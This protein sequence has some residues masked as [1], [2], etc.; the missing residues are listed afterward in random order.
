MKRWSGVPFLEAIRPEPGWQ[1]DRAAFASYSADLVAVMASLLALAGLDDHQGSGS[2]VSVAQAL[3]DLRGRVCFVLQAGRLP[4]PNVSRKILGVLD[5]FLRE[6]KLHEGVQAWH[7]KIAVARMVPSKPGPEGVE[8]RVWIGS[9]NLTR[10]IAF[11]S[12]LT[13]RGRPRLPNTD[14]SSGRI[15]GVGDMIEKLFSQTGLELDIP[16]DEF[17]QIAWESPRDVEVRWLSF[18]LPGEERSLPPAPEGL[19]RLHV[20]SPFLAGGLVRR[21]GGWGDAS[22]HRV[23][24]S[25]LPELSTITAQAQEPL[26]G[27]AELLHLDAP[28]LEPTDIKLVADE[29]E[30]DAQSEDDDEDLGL[31]GL[32]AKLILAEHAAGTALWM[33]SAN[34]SNRAWSGQNSEVV[35]ELGIG[36]ELAK[37]LEQWIADHA[38]TVSLADIPPHEPPAPEEAALEDARHEVASTWAVTQTLGEDGPLLHGAPHPS[39]EA[40]IELEVGLLTG[41]RIPWPRGL[42]PLQLPSI[43]PAFTTELVVVRLRLGSYETQWIQRAPLPDPPGKERDRLAIA[44]FLDA[45]TLL[46][47]LRAL[48]NE[49]EL[50]GQDDD[51]QDERRTASTHDVTDASP[52]W[53]APTLED[54]LRAWSRDP[55]RIHAVDRRV[56]AYFEIMRNRDRQDR[57]PDE[58][59]TKDD[60]MLDAFW[61][62]WQL[63]RAELG[64]GS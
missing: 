49:Q 30:A 54:V 53:W 2:K 55:E 35:A 56:S 42:D 28:E 12:G 59:R 46:A 16:P 19:T 8:W 27:Y 40:T 57:G 9:R 32:H 11:D 37:E 20:V 38:V 45:R 25:T 50:D 34:A 36:D 7:A 63:L 4:T 33:G 51:W 18:N 15:P 64:A 58:P 3:E 29:S 10:T 52:I 60:D 23:L 13:L 61:S 22:T 24:L 14:P 44:R 5:Q 6:A 26:R 43:D 47:W 48:L 21:L 17:E 41:P 39:N 1:V 31:R 62:T